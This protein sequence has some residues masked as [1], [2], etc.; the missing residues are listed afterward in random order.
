LPRNSLNTIHHL[1]DINRAIVEDNIVP[2]PPNTP[3]KRMPY[4]HHPFP[5]FFSHPAANKIAKEKKVAMCMYCFLFQITTIVD[6]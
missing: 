3:H 1:I 2:R 5:S 4:H 6:S